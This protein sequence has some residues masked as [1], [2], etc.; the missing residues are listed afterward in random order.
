MTHTQKKTRFKHV[1]FWGFLN[2]IRVFGYLG[3]IPDEVTP[4][5]VCLGHH[6]EE[7]RLHVI[8]QS[9]MI[10]EE[11]GEE[12]QVLAVDLSTHK[13]K[14]SLLCMIFYL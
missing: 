11:L 1:L 3:E 9:F 4:R 7:K 12:T 5:V 8:I 14:L 10:Q 2:F 6:V 13:Y